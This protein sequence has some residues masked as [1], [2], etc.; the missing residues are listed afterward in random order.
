MS[1]VK[2]MAIGTGYNA[3]TRDYGELIPAGVIDPVMVTHSAVTNAAS[4]GRMVLTTEV[5]IVE[6]PGPGGKKH[7]TDAGVSTIH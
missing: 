6:K 3:A 5:S 1:K 2:E 7:E 4:V